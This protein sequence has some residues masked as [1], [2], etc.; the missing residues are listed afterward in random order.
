MHP[1]LEIDISAILLQLNCSAELIHNVSALELD[2][3]T[4]N[5]ANDKQ[6]YGAILAA[7]LTWRFDKQLAMSILPSRLL[8]ENAMPTKL[9]REESQQILS[10][11]FSTFGIQ[12]SSHSQTLPEL[13]YQLA[14]LVALSAKISSYSDTLAPLKATDNLVISNMSALTE[15]NFEC[16]DDQFAFLTQ[17]SDISH[18]DEPT[19]VL[20]LLMSDIDRM[21]NEL[22]LVK[23]AQDHK[24]HILDPVLLTKEEQYLKTR[25]QLELL[26]NLMNRFNTWCTDYISL[27]TEFSSSQDIQDFGKTLAEFANSIEKAADISKK[28]DILTLLET[29]VSCTISKLE[30]PDALSIQGESLPVAH[31]QVARIIH[32]LEI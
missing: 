2:S 3:D 13:L 9:L 12:Y 17:T 10:T 16:L 32:A 28:L 5:G 29:N 27:S 21:K 7:W 31:D 8:P 22:N 14:K 23:T 6:Q 18:M 15:S 25:S 11:V 20:K 19:T 24:K 30:G 26:G 1:S 4:E